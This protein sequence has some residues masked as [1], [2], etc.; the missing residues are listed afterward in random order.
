MDTLAE[1]Y[2]ANGDYQQAVEIQKKALALDPDNTEL[3]EHMA[4]YR[5]AAGM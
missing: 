2:F 4:R 3:Q 5:Q 1:A